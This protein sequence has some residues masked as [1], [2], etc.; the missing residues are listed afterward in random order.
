MYHT[1]YVASL[2]AAGGGSGSDVRV[3]LLGLMNQQI[4]GG[5]G[6]GTPGWSG[7]GANN[8]RVA[9]SNSSTVVRGKSE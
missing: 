6:S 2:S 7:E 4:L 8:R 5:V 9:K 1:L 3:R